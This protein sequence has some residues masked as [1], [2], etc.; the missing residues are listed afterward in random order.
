MGAAEPLRLSQSETHTD[1]TMGTT[2]GEE[3]VGKNVQADFL[4]GGKKFCCSDFKIPWEKSRSFLC[5]RLN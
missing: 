4:P 5:L 2:E 1:M 3:R